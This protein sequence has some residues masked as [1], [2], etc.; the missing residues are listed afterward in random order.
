[1]ATSTDPAAGPVA[2]GC[3]V[4]NVAAGPATVR[5]YYATVTGALGVEPVWDDRP[6]WTGRILA[7][8]AHTWG[9]T[10]TVDLASALAEIDAG[11]RA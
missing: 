1:V 5:D 9:W 11:L 8:R 3:T 10:P 6:A 4:V 7:G 2:G